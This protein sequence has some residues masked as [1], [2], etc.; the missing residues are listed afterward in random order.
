MRLLHVE[1][2]QVELFLS[3]KR[4]RYAIL[5]HTWEDGAILFEDLQLSSTI[6]WQ[7][8]QGC[9]KVKL[10]CA[11]VR[12]DGFDYVWIDTCCIDKS[13]SAELS[14]AINSMFRWHQEATVCY[15]YFSD[16]KTS[17]LSDLGTCRWFTRGWTLQELIAPNHVEFFGRLWNPLGNRVTLAKVIAEITGIDEEVL[18]RH[19][20]TEIRSLL[21]SITVAQRMYWAS[22]RVTTRKEDIVYCLMGIFDVNMPL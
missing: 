5:S 16:T 1:N 14:E 8:K 19:Q 7:A 3:E 9:H 12:R 22:A 20:T 2:F 18:S 15:A 6:D 13:S 4:P 10:A 17:K 11:Q 21:S